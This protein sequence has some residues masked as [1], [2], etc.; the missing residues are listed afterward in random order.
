MTERNVYQAIIE[1]KLSVPIFNL[2]LEP[3]GVGGHMVYV[4]P[5]HKTRV[6]DIYK[7]RTYRYVHNIVKSE[8]YDIHGDMFVRR[9]AG[10]N[11]VY[12]LYSQNDVMLMLSAFYPIINKLLEEPSQS[13]CYRWVGNIEYLQKK[14]IKLDVTPGTKEGTVQEFPL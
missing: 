11:G 14:G 8:E 10:C 1:G 2:W 4:N 12:A 13:K 7:E 6:S 9:D 3:F 5:E